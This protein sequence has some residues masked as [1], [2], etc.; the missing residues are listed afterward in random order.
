MSSTPKRHIMH[1]SSNI[2]PR[3]KNEKPSPPSY[4]SVK[5]S[6]IIVFTVLQT[7]PSYHQE[8]NESQSMI[9][10][11]HIRPKAKKAKK[12]RK[13]ERTHRFVR[14]LYST[15]CPQSLQRI[16]SPRFRGTRAEHSP[17]MYT[18]EGVSAAAAPPLKPL[19]PKVVCAPI[20]GT[21]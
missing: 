9:Q 7:E 13:K 4:P 16:W 5:H 2:K 3:R 19:S 15:R 11:P 17:Q 12:A 8:K 10:L 6:S 14:S 18:Q 21:W 1:H 20:E